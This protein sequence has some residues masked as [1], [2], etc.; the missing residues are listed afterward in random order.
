MKTC[1]TSPTL[2]RGKQDFKM[3]TMKMMITCY[4]LIG[5]VAILQPEVRILFNGKWC[6]PCLCV[7][8]VWI[9]YV[10]DDYRFYVICFHLSETGR[11]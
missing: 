6:S 1:Q 5:F 8:P 11:F 3:D 7:V 10:E 9:Y 2:G 4:C